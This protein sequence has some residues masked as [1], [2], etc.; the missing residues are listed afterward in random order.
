MKSVLIY[1]C[2]SIL[3]ISAIGTAVGYT[4]GK[5]MVFRKFHDIDD[6]WNIIA[7][8]TVEG[9][10]GTATKVKRQLYCIVTCH[11]YLALILIYL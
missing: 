4:S 11:Y 1:K 10:L 2:I 6:I 7:K 8:A 9:T 5:W 3:L